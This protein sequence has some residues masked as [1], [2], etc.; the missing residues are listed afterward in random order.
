MP[1]IRGKKMSY[2][3]DGMKKAGLYK[4]KTKKKS[5]KKSA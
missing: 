4:K 3:K 5:K 1:N 2:L